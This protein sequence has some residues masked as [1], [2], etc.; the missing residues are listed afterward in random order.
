M[1]KSNKVLK[2]A[3]TLPD[4]CYWCIKKCDEHCKQG[5]TPI[6]IKYGRKQDD[7]KK[8]QCRNESRKLVKTRSIK[9]INECQICGKK[10]IKL[11]IHH[12]NYD[13]PTQIAILCPSCHLSYHHS[14]NKL[15]KIAGALGMPPAY[16]LS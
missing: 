12:F 1:K 14:V 6:V 3:Y 16:F 15:K 7:I 10:H 5:F 11:H 4:V 9:V 8:D 13:D 2:K